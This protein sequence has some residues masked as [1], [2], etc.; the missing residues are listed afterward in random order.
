MLPLSWELVCFLQVCTYFVNLYFCHRA[1]GLVLTKRC[2]F[3][4][5]LYNSY[6]KVWF[7]WRLYLFSPFLDTAKASTVHMR[8]DGKTFLIIMKI[9]FLIIWKS[10][11]QSQWL[12]SV[13]KANL[14]SFFIF[15][16]KC[17]LRRRWRLALP[18]AFLLIV[19]HSP[20]IGLNIY[21]MSLV[22]VFTL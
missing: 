7:H 8:G 9:V 17:N 21:E 2:D 11:K 10:M 5:L 4:K 18:A 15:L 19:C 1:Q 22:Y 12:W 13:R 3:V 16:R 6:K 20:R 14:D